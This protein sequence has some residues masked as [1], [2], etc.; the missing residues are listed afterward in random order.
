MYCHIDKIAI[1]ETYTVESK[2][3]AMFRELI[4]KKR[5][6]FNKL[7]PISACHKAE[8]VTAFTGLLEL[9][10]RSKVITKQETLFG[11]I[12]VEKKKKENTVV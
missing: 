9:S 6:V 7:F 5:F 4:Q 11:N 8:V 10:R 3:K 2:V 1:T 12:E